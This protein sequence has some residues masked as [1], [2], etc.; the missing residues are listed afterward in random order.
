LSAAQRKLKQ[1]QSRAAPRPP[2]SRT[3]PCHPKNSL[4]SAG[5]THIPSRWRNTPK[6]AR[7]PTQTTN[8]AT[9]TAAAAALLRKLSCLHRKACQLYPMRFEMLTS[10]EKMERGVRET[11]RCIRVW[12]CSVRGEIQEEQN[13]GLECWRR[14]EYLQQSAMSTH[15]L[16]KARA[17]KKRKEESREW[18]G[19]FNNACFWLELHQRGELLPQRAI[20]D[21]SRLRSYPGCDRMWNVAECH[22]HLFLPSWPSRIDPVWRHALS[23]MITTTAT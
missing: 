12:L 17:K 4:I 10:S 22:S 13:R 9:H 3:L 20:D 7:P 5:A 6:T 11:C 19:V 21:A 2:P 18:Q 8:A 23:F 15:F 16:L 1:M 14:G